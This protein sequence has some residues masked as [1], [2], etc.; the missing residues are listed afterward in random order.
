MKWQCFV[1]NWIMYGGVYD[2]Q[3]IEGPCV[4]KRD[5]RYYCLFSAG[6]WENETYG[7]D[8][9]VS[10]HVL[11]PYACD[12]SEDG[13]RVLRTIPGEVLGPGHNSMTEGPNAT[14]YIVYHAGDPKMIARRM[15]IDPVEWTDNGPEDASVRQRPLRFSSELRSGAKL[16]GSET[17]VRR[18]K[19]CHPGLV[20]DFGRSWALR[21]N[22]LL[23]RNTGSRLGSDIPDQ[24]HRGSRPSALRPQPCG[25]PQQPY[26]ALFS[27]DDP[28]HLGDSVL[29]EVFQKNTFPGRSLYSKART[30]EKRTLETAIC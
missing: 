9:A 4:R 2:W 20:G 23:L 1:S 5:G 10:D 8:F 17:Y 11:G 29:W 28:Y 18:A 15:F 30:M 22:L 21:K 14:D 19:S 3:T 26:P 7:V 16:A 13:A 27:S 12:S 24:G 6:R 25:R